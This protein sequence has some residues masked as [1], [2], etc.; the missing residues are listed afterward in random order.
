MKS[1]AEKREADS[2]A[3]TERSESKASH[4]MKSEILNKKLQ[5]FKNELTLTE[6][7]ISNLHEQC[8]WLLEHHEERKKARAV[9]KEG[10]Q[11]TVSVLSSADFS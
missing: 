6:T 8:D 10:L 4:E 3:I 1:S 2:R 11:K 5:G 7:V 9:E